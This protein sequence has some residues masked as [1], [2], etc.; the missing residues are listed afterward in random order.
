M[1]GYC[2]V[3]PLS[4]FT[5]GGRLAPGPFADAMVSAKHPPVGPG[6]SGVA[7]LSEAILGSR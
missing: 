6:S 2:L 1:W 3:C 5:V 4:I 7:T